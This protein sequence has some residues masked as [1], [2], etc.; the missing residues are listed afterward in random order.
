M[1]EH[2][3]FTRLANGIGILTF[4]K[5]EAQSVQLAIRVRVG[6]RNETEALNG[7]SHFIEHMLFKGTPS[8]SAKMIS[9]TI[10]GVGGSINAFTDRDN[11]CYYTKVPYDKAKIAFDVLTDL[12]Y[13]A[14]FD[15]KEFDRERN[16]ITEEI[17]M[18]DDQPDSV[19]MDQLIQ[20]LWSGHPL[21]RPILG[22]IDT[23]QSV[24]RK[25]I[26]AYRKA[27]YIPSRT[28]YSFCGRIDHKTCVAMVSKS[29]G[30]L[31]NPSFVR[32]AEVYSP[33][34]PMDPFA[35]TRR[36]IQ[37]T[38]VA[39]GWRIPG[40]AD[41]AGYPY[42]LCALSALL[43]ESMMSRLFQSIRER[44][45]LCYNINSFTT[46]CN[47]NGALIIAAGCDPKKA[48]HGTKAILAEIR[49]LIEKPIPK[50]EFKRT[51]EYICGRFRLRMDASPMGWYAGRALFDRPMDPEADIA[52]LRALTPQ[53]LQT[54]A[55]T[56][57]RP[58]QLALSIVA[59]THAQHGAAEWCSL[60]NY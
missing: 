17:R 34:I 11:T 32:E 44:R 51:I 19:A 31:R 42:A 41:K 7:A 36:E 9:Q 47:D 40:F 48:Y 60:M 55:A 49:K 26:L 52:A 53:D 18:Y 37:Q 39:M 59:P 58:E 23:I 12:F 27:N 25:D 54:A 45:A 28:I 43:G 13:N 10:E 21:G 15:A 4:S 2:L 8:R 1:L 35:L 33:A 20:Q 24:S 56:Y 14:S 57:L 30:R 6:S 16:V 3:K 22:P 5:P 50:A 29:A 46:L 38:Q